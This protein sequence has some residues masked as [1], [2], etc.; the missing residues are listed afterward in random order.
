[1]SKKKISIFVVILIFILCFIFFIPKNKECTVVSVDSPI[2]IHLENSNFNITDLES[3]DDTFSEH[4]KITAKSLGISEI[5]A[6][7]L[8]NLS[9]YWAKN[10]LEGRSV[11]IKN[12]D[13]IFNKSS[14]KNKFMYSGFCLKNAKPYYEDGFKKQLINISKG[15]YKVIDTKTDININE[16]DKENNNASIKSV[17]HTFVLFIHHSPLIN[18]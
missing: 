4:N 16:K 8:G 12:N 11:I 3:F 14:Y 18:W 9:K 15:H 5:D 13:L 1:M 10:L 17:L 7:V 2:S 6:F